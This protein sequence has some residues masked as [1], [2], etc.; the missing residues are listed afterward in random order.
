MFLH[1]A[2][3]GSVRCARPRRTLARLTARVGRLLAVA[4]IVASGLLPGEA[5]ASTVL[6]KTDAELVAISERVVHARV[7]RHRYE[8][9][10]GSDGAIF[11]VT[12]LAVLE[13]FTGL[14]G[15]TVDV[16]ELGGVIGDETMFVGGGV[17]YQVGSEVLVCLG[18][19]NFGL[20]SVA[21]GFSKF[22]VTPVA[23]LNGSIDGRLTRN[24]R[25][26]SVV[27]GAVQS[28]ERSLSEFRSLVAA[29]RGVSSRRNS[30]AESLVPDESVSEDFTFLGSGLRWVEADSGTPVRYYK[31]L[32]QP[33]P[34]SSG[35][36]DTE[37]QTA[38]AAWTNPTT[39]SITLQLAGTT[40][41][42]DPYAPVSSSGTAVISFE[43]PSGEINN[44]TLAIG[45]GWA[46]TG[47]GVINGT[48]FNKFT[49]GFV[50]FQ[51]AVDLPAS[52]K[53]PLNFTRVLEHEVGHTIGL[54][55]STLATSIM[56][57]SC[58]SASTP[59]APALG[60][61]DLDGLNFIYPAGAAPACTFSLSPSAATANA[62]GATGTIGVNVLTGTGC[63]WTAMSN[64]SFV[65]LN[66]S[67]GTGN[68]TLAYSVAANSS[69]NQRVATLTIAGQTFT[70]TQAGAAAA[71]LP[72]FG[73]VDTPLDNAA[74][75]TGS[76]PVTGWALDDVKVT[77]VKVYRDPV[78]GEPVGTVYIGTATF[79]P[80]ARPDIA[81][82]YPTTPFNTQAG[83]GYLLLTNVLPN[84][85]TGT[86]RLHLYATDLEG[87]QKLLGSR[88]I[89]CTNSTA[90]T[91][92]GAIDTPAQGEVVTT[93][94]FNN[95]GWVLS[96]PTPRADPPGGGTVRVV[97]DGAI[98]GT[99]AGWTSRSDL[100]ALFPLSLYPGVNTAL[101]VYTFNTTGLANGQHTI[102]WSVTDSMG[103]AA[104][105]GS[106]YFT[107]ASGGPVSGSSETVGR[108]AVGGWVNRAA[109]EPA[110]ISGRR[111]FA[112]DAPL[113]RF[114]PDASGLVTVHAEE[115]DRIELH[116]ADAQSTASRSRYRGYLRAGADLLPLPIGSSLDA[117]TGE[118]TWQPGV[119]FV[120]A[121]DFVFIRSADG[122]AVARQEVRIVLHPKASGYVGSQIVID[123]PTRQQ[124]VGQP[125]VLAGWAIDLDDQ[126]GTGID[127]LHVWA[128]PLAGG[129]P[130]FVGA[131]AYGGARPD[132]AALHGNR[133]KGSGFSLTVQGLAPGNYDLAVFGWST[134]AGGFA[135]AKTVRVTVR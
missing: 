36:I 123:T 66:V 5:H 71:T 113:R 11:T 19:G 134:A 99:P 37:I 30:A 29:V 42:T 68:A 76:I 65:T 63:T 54:G 94:T 118:I 101:A 97:I 78:A 112:L 17:K 95:F 120:G 59:I 49:R 75:V 77:S 125:F 130:I 56:F 85:G 53:D 62:T 15:D 72:P 133:F 104:G 51:N 14:P 21:M 6:Y 69:T 41:Q 67:G 124:D 48:T 9:P 12:T 52:F 126:V 106:R 115:I 33:S 79:V 10:G 86:Y 91:P 16:W 98:A 100:S 13:D 58:C 119:G 103:G 22:D 80:G 108:A 88:T 116:L 87:N 111:G 47:G 50:I 129:D 20:R 61:D 31:N 105:V 107:V 43:D 35:N 1:L 128:Y 39:A 93:A 132:V 44:P 92:F 28:S 96:L 7:L 26:T 81:A 27:G 74:G 23:A 82:A 83:W 109:L 89:T 46:S 45:G 70:I 32:A 34:L 3:A 122:H 2:R 8:R 127:T 64:A 40:T 4:T 73:V 135:P 117:A 24:L 38:L 114:R 84:R 57:A 25:D 110:V 18:R 102:A 60:P 55:H 131:A 90:T 121:Y